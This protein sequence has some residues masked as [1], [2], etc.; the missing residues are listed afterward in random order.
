MT[1]HKKVKRIY[2]DEKFS[3]YHRLDI[4]KDGKL[5]V[6]DLDGTLADVQH[7]VHFLDGKKKDWVGFLSDVKNDTPKDWVIEILRLLPPERVLLFTGRSEISAVDTIEWLDTY[8]I[9]YAEL[10]MRWSH[11]FEPDE[12]L[13]LRMVA[14][15]VYMKSIQNRIQAIWD[16]RQRVVD[17]WR[18]SGFNVFQVEKWE[19]FDRTMN[20]VEGVK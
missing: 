13:K 20:E 1:N 2:T 17:M 5:Y 12:I 6:F 11:N 18:D 9:P 7:R 10:R 4:P 8:N 15:D 14:D 16:D 3:V 19:E